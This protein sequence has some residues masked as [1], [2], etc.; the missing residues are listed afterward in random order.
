MK[1]RLAPSSLALSS[2]DSPLSPAAALAAPALLDAV[3]AGRFRLTPADGGA[4]PDSL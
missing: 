1:S 3:C 4:R 2:S